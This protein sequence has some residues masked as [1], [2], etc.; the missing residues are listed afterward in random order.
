M[1]AQEELEDA[2]SS[3]NR[4]WIKRASANVVNAASAA[5]GFQYAGVS[6]E[7]SQ[8]LT[9]AMRDLTRVTK[10]NAA[11]TGGSTQCRAFFRRASIAKL[12]GTACY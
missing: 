10:T 7:D 11:A 9:A 3:G 8:K 1:A 5:M 4:S 2:R 6:A 12:L